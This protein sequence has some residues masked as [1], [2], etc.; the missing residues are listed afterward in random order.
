MA[1]HAFEVTARSAAPAAVVFDVLADIPR[2]HEWAGPFVRESILDT[3]GKDTDVGVGAVR[4]LGSRPVYSR[5]E[6]VEFDRPSHLAYTLLSGMPIRG[7]R[8]DVHLTPDPGG[9]TTIR[10]QGAF[11]PVIAGTGGALRWFLRR[12]IARVASGLASAAE[13]RH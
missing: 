13:K 10:W 7:Y 4:K 2:W 12:T 11:D 1:H 5:E 8:A 9:G 3:P 6:I